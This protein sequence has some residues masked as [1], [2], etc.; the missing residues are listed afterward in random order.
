MLRFLLNYYGS[1]RTCNWSLLIVSDCIS[2]IV[3]LNN[4][5]TTLSQVI[6]LSQARLFSFPENNIHSGSLL[7]WQR[8]PVA[9]HQYRLSKKEFDQVLIIRNP[10]S[11]QEACSKK[12]KHTLS[13]QA[14]T[15]GTIG[16][17]AGHSQRNKWGICGSHVLPYIAVMPLSAV[18]NSQHAWSLS[19]LLSHKV[20]LMK[21]LTLRSKLFQEQFLVNQKSIFHENFSDFYGLPFQD[22]ALAIGWRAASRLWHTCDTSPHPQIIPGISL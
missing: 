8:F 22:L 9:T 14:D 10:K 11:L 15:P 17:L 1:R 5:K 4:N 7:Y 16:M 21:W 18:Q 20:N 12:S 19:I 2:A 3:I 13:L 6:G